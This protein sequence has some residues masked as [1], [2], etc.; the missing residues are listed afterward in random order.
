MSRKRLL[1]GLLVSTALACA[2]CVGSAAGTDA[3]ANTTAQSVPQKVSND[4]V[5][6]LV[7]LGASVSDEDFKLLFADPVQKKYPN[8]TLKSVAP[9][10]GTTINELIASGT[11]PDLI[12]TPNAD[13][14][15]YKQQDL[16]YDIAPLLKQ[17]KIDLSRFLPATIDAVKSDKGEVWA[18]PYAMQF[19]T[20]YYNKDVFDKFGV[21]YPKDGMTWDNAIELGKKVTRKDGSVQY[22]GLD[23]VSSYLMSFPFAL[24]YVNGKTNKSAM[25]DPKWKS[26]F[27]ITKQIQTIPGNEPPKPEPGASTEADY[28]IKDKNIAMLV[29]VNLMVQ[30]GSA[31]EKG[32]N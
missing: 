19:D 27:E 26:V 5:T 18:V 17:N 11:I 25:T 10:K 22:R 2:G 7:Y 9:A 3:P 12:T 1:F 30:M 14:L 28:F 13:M 16:L 32:L 31:G 6:L 29:S 21:A 4:P 15:G 24:P 23:V 20:M 8:I